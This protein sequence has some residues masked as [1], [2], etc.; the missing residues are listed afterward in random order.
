MLPEWLFKLAFILLFA[1]AVAIRVHYQRIAGTYDHGVARHTQR[2]LTHE[3][4]L[5]LLLRPLLGLPWYGV[6]LGWLFAPRWV[7]WSFLPAPLWLRTAGVLLG[8]LGLLLLWR[9]HAALG[10]N[11]RPTLEISPGQQLVTIG[12]Y[13]R[14]R[15]PIYAAFLLLLAST[16]FLSANWFIGTVGIALIASITVVRIPAEEALLE[17]HFGECYRQYRQRTPALLPGAGQTAGRA[18]S[19]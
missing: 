6:V 1:C 16:G 10:K 12:P 13:A 5:L 8:G 4:K 19:A 11:F 14:V 7:T 18:A 17:Q 9:S 2:H 15:H 3:A